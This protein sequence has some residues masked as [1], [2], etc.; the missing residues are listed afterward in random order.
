MVRIHKFT[1][2]A[3]QSGEE[4]TIFEVENGQYSRIIYTNQST[5]IDYATEMQEWSEEMRSKVCKNLFPTYQI[6]SLLR[7][8][9]LDPT[10]RSQ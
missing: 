3:T 2:C 1:D 4:M 10:Y 6:L 7:T 5:R 8:I 9:V